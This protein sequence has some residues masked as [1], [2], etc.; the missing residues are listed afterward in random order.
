M[1][2]QNTVAVV[3]L[4]IFLITLATAAQAASS[5]TGTNTQTDSTSKIENS[6]N[7][8][9]QAKE[10]IRINTP[11]GNDSDK[12][13]YQAQVT[14]TI[15]TINTNELP[16]KN[17]EDTNVQIQPNQ[18][19]ANITQKPLAKGPT[20]GKQTRSLNGGIFTEQPGE[21]ENN[22]PKEPFSPDDFPASTDDS[23]KE[24]TGNAESAPE[25]IQMEQNIAAQESWSQKEM[26][27]GNEKTVIGKK[28]GNE[29]TILSGGLTATTTEKIE[30]TNN[31]LTADGKT[32]MVTP[33]MA[34]GKAIQ[35][36]GIAAIQKITL[37]TESGPIYTIETR[38]TAKLLWFIP[39]E[40]ETKTKIDAQTSGVVSTEKPWWSFLIT[41]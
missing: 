6:A 28:T 25:T 35:T 13:G 30:I 39:V 34:A 22:P 5:T 7:K 24:L 38:K 10:P 9:V 3:L 14:P 8:A 15:A 27:L 40:V 18:R 11:S 4:L 23:A 32:I 29:T 2:S 41:E 17:P 31:Q 26:M 19:D 37:Q 36:T 12:N 16:A 20:P 21:P 33:S 1:V